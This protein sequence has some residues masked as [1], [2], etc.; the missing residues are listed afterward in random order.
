MSW[1][2]FAL[3]SAVTYGTYY[4]LLKRNINREY[5]WSYF[6]FFFTL[7]FVLLIPFTQW[8]VFPKEQAVWGIILLHVA[9][10]S[11]FFFFGSLAYKHLEE[12]EVS[13][14]GNLGLIVLIFAG[15]FL[16]KETLTVLQLLGVALMI[17][18][19]F[20][21]EA[22]IHISK[23]KRIFKS[24]NHR[25][26]LYCILIA[27]FFSVISSIVEKVILDP[28]ALEF[29]ITPVEPFSLNY[30]TRGLLMC[31]FLSRAFFKKEFI[32]RF[33]HVYHHAGWTILLAAIVYNIAN[34][35]YFT[36]LSLGNFSEVIPVASLSTLFIVIVGGS[37]FHEHHLKQKIVA[38]IIMIIATG[39]IVA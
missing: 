8:V 29:A 38:S 16:F 17:I 3:V 18:G 6:A 20:I 22:G 2:V 37:L 28:Q 24:K 39:L 19:A 10:L 12:S 13:P 9:L 15:I 1:L 27:I 21:L 5:I 14:L 35:S 7:L 32:P 36:A 25:K 33:K 34:I 4:V 26:Y 30:I 11:L 23:F 31:F